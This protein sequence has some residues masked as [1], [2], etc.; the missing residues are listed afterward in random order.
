MPNRSGIPRPMLAVTFGEVEDGGDPLSANGGEI[1][2]FENWF[3]TTR[4]G[5]LRE[6]TYVAAPITYSA[7]RFV[8]SLAGR[9]GYSS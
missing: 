2:F 8:R 7:Y 1:E 5:R 4:L 9:K 6:R 3:H